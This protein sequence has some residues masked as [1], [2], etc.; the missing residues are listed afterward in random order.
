MKN[1][2]FAK[3]SFSPFKKIAYFFIGNTSNSDPVGFITFRDISLKS[4]L[5]FIHTKWDRA[6]F[7]NITKRFMENRDHPSGIRGNNGG[8][9]SQHGAKK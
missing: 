7:R 1:V 5:S 3:K 6:N 4:K 2:I 9:L 8:S